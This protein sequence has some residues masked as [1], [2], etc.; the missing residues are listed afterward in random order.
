MPNIMVTER[1]NL[2]C[3]YCFAREKLAVQD[4]PVAEFADVLHKMQQWGMHQIGIIGGEPTLHS[5]FDTILRLCI[6]S[7]IEDFTVFT[8]GVEMDAYAPLLAHPKIGILV[9][10]NSR[11]NM[12]DEAYDR[13]NHNILAAHQTY[14]RGNI[15][16]GLNVH[17]ASVPQ[18]DDLLKLAMELRLHKIRFSL[19]V[20]TY[21]Y[22]AKHSILEYFKELK[23]TFLALCLMF[24]AHGIA[25]GLDCNYIPDCV[26][27]PSELITLQALSEK[28]SK[29]LGERVSYLWHNHC[30]PVLDILCGKRVIRCFG[31][32]D[33]SEDLDCF[34][35]HHEASAYFQ[36]TVD[37][38]AALL[39][40]S[41]ACAGCD[42][43]AVCN[44]GCI[45]AKAARLEGCRRVCDD[46]NA[47][48]SGRD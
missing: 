42:T 2:Q 20:P 37:R 15:R 46:L 41:G 31:C 39:D 32:S 12:G 45:R 22:L 47:N 8:N 5:Q 19:S 16:L 24:D 13:M 35:S 11:E 27:T 26:F 17:T 34:V 3:P 29:K 23:N 25:L 38:Y 9:N 21:D 6:Q 1:C 4:M 48:F 36:R 43:A 44:M 40:I 10:Y 30:R 14:A 18:A 33:I 7:P 28:Y